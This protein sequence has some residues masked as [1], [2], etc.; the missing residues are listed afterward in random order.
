MSRPK[1]V[2]LAYS[3]GL[4]TSII[5]K[6]LQTEY[7]CEVV[8]FTADDAYSWIETNTNYSKGGEYDSKRK[9]YGWSVL[10]GYEY[11]QVMNAIRKFAET[12]KESYFICR[13]KAPTKNEDLN[14]K[15]NKILKE[16]SYLEECL[17]DVFK[18]HQENKK[19]PWYTEA[20]I[21]QDTELENST[22]PILLVKK[23]K[24]VHQ[25]DSHPL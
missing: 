8:T 17:I 2:V 14:A 21:P 12:G 20:F 24:R 13:T 4:D 9:K 15:R 16:L 1:K 25:L 10:E 22:K 6:W 3:G 18:Y 23:G 19:F 5:L 11:E 7:G